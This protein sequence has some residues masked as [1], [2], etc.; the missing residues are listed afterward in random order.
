MDFATRPAQ[1]VLTAF[2]ARRYYLDD[3]SKVEIANELG[4]SRFK[5]ARLI[6]AARASGLVRIEIADPGAIDVDLST[7]LQSAFGLRHAVVVDTPDGDPTTLRQDLGK[8]AAALLTEIVTVDDVF[9]LAWSRSVS[10]M[11]N[12]LTQLPNVP[13]VQLTGALVRPGV[14]DNSVDLVRHAARVSGGA[15]HFFYAPTIV[16]DPATARALHKQPEIARTFARFRSVTK[17]VVGVGLWAPDESTV[18]DATEAKT[19]RELHRRGVCGEVSGILIDANGDPIESD[20]TNRMIGISA[21]QLRAIPE[22]I[23]LAYSTARAPAVKAAIRGGL[24][25]SVITHTSLA[26]ALLT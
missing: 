19:R 13:V 12:A 24:V 17:A 4:L 22:V 8:A 23:T 21:A 6:D 9:G 11:T 18:H 7:K 20:L 5:V 15:A 2:V 1:L 16:S 25:N 3:R 10:A 14:D 26:H